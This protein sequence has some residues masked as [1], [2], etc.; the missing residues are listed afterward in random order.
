MDLIEGAEVARI[1]KQQY[2]LMAN[3]GIWEDRR[4]ELVFGVV[5]E[6]P[7]A[8]PPHVESTR[9]VHEALLRALADRA[10]VY[11]QSAFDANA[12]SLPEPDVAVVPLGDYWRS[13]ASRAHLI[14]EVA[15]SS[16]RYDR[17]T[18]AR[19]YSRSDVD[20]Y[21]V[22]DHNTRTVIA[23]RDRADIGWATVLTYQEGQAIS[24]VAFPDVSLAVADLLPPRA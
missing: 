5:V 11:S 18:K 19:L 7:P 16:A 13:H 6:M 12:D 20:E 22:V 23:H 10:R 21:W 1:S 8:D 14:V 24:P 9:V 15:R 17:T 3:Q 2:L 4:V